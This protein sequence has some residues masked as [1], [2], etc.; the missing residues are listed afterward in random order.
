MVCYLRV[1]QSA[2]ENVNSGLLETQK[3]GRVATDTHPALNG[4][5]GWNLLH[6]AEFK[7][8]TEDLDTVAQ[9]Y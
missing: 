2:R 4:L 1:W 9:L 3:R 6:N 8:E 7:G 5:Q